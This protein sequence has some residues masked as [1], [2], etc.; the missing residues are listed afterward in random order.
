MVNVRGADV[1]IASLLSGRRQ[2]YVLE[3]RMLA[4]GVNW[5]LLKPVIFLLH[6]AGAVPALRVLS[7]EDINESWRAEMPSLSLFC[8]HI[9]CICSRFPDTSPNKA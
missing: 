5:L 4:G 9:I 7:E 1:W 3:Q 2:I 8:R 6:A